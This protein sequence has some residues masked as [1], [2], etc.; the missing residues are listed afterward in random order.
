MPVPEEP[1]QSQLLPAML[2]KHEDA[3][4]LPT[5]T[6]GIGSHMAFLDSIAQC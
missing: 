3:G 1:R 6:C 4:L 2:G 5:H